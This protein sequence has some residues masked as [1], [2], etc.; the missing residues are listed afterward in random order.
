M[1]SDSELE[2]LRQ[3]RLR[4]LAQSQMQQQAQQQMQRALQE[5][6]ISAQIKVIINQILEPAAKERLSNIHAARP[7][8]AR[9][10]EILLI[11]LYQAGQLPARLSDDAFKKILERIH[12]K[13]R[14]PK[15]T[16]S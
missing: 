2:A 4:E 11:Q 15:I 3:R 5:D 14:E 6:Q 13:K 7:E 1:S 12:E 10:I 8:F 16:R 9:Q